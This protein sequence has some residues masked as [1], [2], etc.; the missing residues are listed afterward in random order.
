MHFNFPI[1]NHFIEWWVY[2]RGVFVRGVFVRRVFVRAVFVRGVFVRRVFVLIPILH[3]ILIASL[4][5]SLARL[6]SVMSGAL[7]SSNFELILELIR[8]IFEPMS[9]TTVVSNSI[10][11]LPQACVFVDVDNNTNL[12]SEITVKINLIINL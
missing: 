4:A 9:L 2:V 12:L 5:V 11:V 7:N 3:T 6:T 1:F 10:S 8:L